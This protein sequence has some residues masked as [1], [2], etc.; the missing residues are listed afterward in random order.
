V[1]WEELAQRPRFEPGSKRG[2]EVETIRGHGAGNE[3]PVEAELP[4]DDHL[5]DASAGETRAI[6]PAAASASGPPASQGFATAAA[7]TMRRASRKGGTS[8]EA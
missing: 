5:T 7:G 4:G 8:K 2:E 6:V 1:R 3:P